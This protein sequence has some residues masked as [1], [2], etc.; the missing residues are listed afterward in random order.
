MYMVTTCPE[1]L[2]MLRNLTAVRKFSKRQ[3][4]V[5]KSFF[6][7][8]WLIVNFTF[9]AKAVFSSIVVVK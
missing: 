1:S 8:K 2:E 7:G 9:E 5:G 6:H 4:G 3:E